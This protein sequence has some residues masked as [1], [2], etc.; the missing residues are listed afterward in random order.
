MT[1]TLYAVA[2]PRQ[3]L[4][5]QLAFEAVLLITGKIAGAGRLIGIV[6]NPVRREI[7]EEVVDVGR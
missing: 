2:F 6:A 3:R 4:G 5:R 7:A 1:C